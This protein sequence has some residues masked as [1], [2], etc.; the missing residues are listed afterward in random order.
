MVD[1]HSAAPSECTF[2]GIASLGATGASAVRLHRLTEGASSA[3]K[4]G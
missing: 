3:S 2:A 4:A 1:V